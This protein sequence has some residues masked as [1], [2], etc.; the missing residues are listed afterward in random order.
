MYRHRLRLGT[1]AD[2]GPPEQETESLCSQVQELRTVP[3]EV[4]DV[5]LQA[6]RSKLR[7]HG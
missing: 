4:R 2:C 7:L 6:I 1:T 5:L 3:I